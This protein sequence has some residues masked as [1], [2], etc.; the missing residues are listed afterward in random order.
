[1]CSVDADLFTSLADA[2]AFVAAR[3]GGEVRTEIAGTVFAKGLKLPGRRQADAGATTAGGNLMQIK[4]V[5]TVAVALLALPAAAE[6]PVVDEERLD[7]LRRAWRSQAGTEATLEA[8][9][10]RGEHCEIRALPN[11][12]AL[13]EC[14]NHGREIAL[15]WQHATGDLANHEL[16]SVLCTTGERG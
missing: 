8:M 11:T 7:S 3:G 2:I 12:T 6:E 1:M 10:C 9:F 14:Q 4:F 15:E 16:S 13:W 5:L